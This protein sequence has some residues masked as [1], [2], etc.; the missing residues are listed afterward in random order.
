MKHYA[1]DAIKYVIDL[2]Y[3]KRLK[4]IGVR[5]KSLFYWV[6]YN[7]VN[8]YSMGVVYGQID[9]Q[10]AKFCETFSAF[11]SEEL[12]DL[13]PARLQGWGDLTCIKDRDSGGWLIGYD[14]DL[15]RCAVSSRSEANT[16]AK[17]LIYLFEKGWLKINQ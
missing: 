4:G 1:H 17:M 5:Q 3:A 14:P 7:A 8:Y 11:T 2:E 10:Q 15:V 9:E 13:L 12:S 6:V 16:R